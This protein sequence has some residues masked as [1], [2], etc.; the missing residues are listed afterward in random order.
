MSEVL[1]ECYDVPSICY[2]VDSMFSF[3]DKYPNQSGLIVSIGYHAI[4]ILPILFG[5]IQT[6]KSRRINL[7]GYQMITFLHRLFQLKYPV[8]AAAILLSRIE[9]LLHN[10]CSI[11]YDYNAELKKWSKLDF[12][13][14]NVKK[15]QLA[16]NQNQSQSTQQ[17]TTEQKFEK[18]RELAKRLAEINAR[19]REE[20]LIDDQK[21][22]MKLNYIKTCSERGENKEFQK[23]MKR[24]VINGKDEL[25]V[26]G[27]HTFLKLKTDSYFY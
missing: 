14:Q 5:S 24:N 4:H 17:L 20:R 25:N 7:G 9:W 13:E 6:T 11:A 22:L 2:G 8:H 18:K 3:N 19:K 27:F 16:F 26:N 23:L 10:Y 12:Y 21:Q 15:I 1:F